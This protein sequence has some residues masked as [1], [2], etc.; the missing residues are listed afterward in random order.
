MAT[1]R[2]FLGVTMT[3]RVALAETP[4]LSVTV[5]VTVS[6]TLAVPLLVKAWLAAAPEAV[7][8][9]PKLQA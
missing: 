6:V 3:E 7:P 5:R 1:V 4:V 8:P 2:V 9:S